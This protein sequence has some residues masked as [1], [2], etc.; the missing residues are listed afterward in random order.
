MK[1]IKKL[2]IS[3]LTICL[4]L[5][6]ITVV[7]AEESSDDKT[8]FFSSTVL[9]SLTGSN[10]FNL[11]IAESQSV[12]SS[13][14]FKDVPIGSVMNDGYKYFTG[15]ENNYSL[16]E[17]HPATYVDSMNNS[18]AYV[19][20]GVIVTS[21]DEAI[22][23]SPSIEK[24]TYIKD[25][26]DNIV[27]EK[28]FALTINANIMGFSTKE[29]IQ[30]GLEKTYLYIY[31]D[32]TQV[33]KIP[34]LELY[35]NVYN[36]GYLGTWDVK[37]TQ[38]DFVKSEVT[39][40]DSTVQKVTG[41]NLN[42]S[43]SFSDADCIDW[44]NT[45]EVTNISG[46][47]P[48]QCTSDVS[49]YTLEVPC[50][51]D[52][53]VEYKAVSDFGREITGSINIT[54]FED[55]VDP[56]NPELT[57]LKPTLKA[58][59]IP[60]SASEAFEISIVSDIEA[61]VNSADGL[62]LMEELK[63]SDTRYIYKFLINNNGT[64]K[65]EGSPINGG[66][67][68]ELS[69]EI[70]CFSNTPSD[71]SDNPSSIED[72]D[73]KPIISIDDAQASS[74][75]KIIAP[76][77]GDTFNML[78]YVLMTLGSL[79]LLI[80]CM[81]KKKRGMA[82]F[83]A[84]LMILS[85][86]PLT[87]VFSPVEIFAQ[88]NT[89]NEG[90][91]G[92]VSNQPNGV[93]AMGV[94]HAAYRV[95]MIDVNTGDF[96]FLKNNKA[97]FLNLSSLDT[98]KKL[99]KA[100]VDSGKL[101][102]YD[103]KNQW[104][105]TF[106]G[107]G[108]LGNATTYRSIRDNNW[109][110]T[111]NT[112]SI[113]TFIGKL[114]TIWGTSETYKTICWFN[115]GFKYNA[116]NI[117]DALDSFLNKKDP[118]KKAKTFNEF[119]YGTFSADSVSGKYLV[120][121]PC[122]EWCINGTTDPQILPYSLAY[123]MKSKNDFSMYS[124]SSF[125]ASNNNYSLF[126]GDAYQTEFID[127][128]VK[129]A[130]A[131]TKK[132]GVLFYFMD[133]PKVT[134]YGK[135]YHYYASDFIGASIPGSTSVN[136]YTRLMRRIDEVTYENGKEVSSK[137]I[138]YEYLNG[139]SWKELKSGSTSIDKIGNLSASTANAYTVATSNTRIQTFKTTAGAHYGTTILSNLSSTKPSAKWTTT[140][141]SGS[142]FNV[143]NK[144]TFAGLT[145]GSS[146]NFDA[147]ANAIAN[148]P[149]L[150]SVRVTQNPSKQSTTASTITNTSWTV[151]G[152]DGN[153]T[154]HDTG[155]SKSDANSNIIDGSTGIS[156]GMIYG[157]KNSS[158]TS[159]VTKV[160]VAFKPTGKNTVTVTSGDKTSNYATNSSGKFNLDY[161]GLQYIV[162]VPNYASKPSDAT[163]KSTLKGAYTE[164]IN[165]T[166]QNLF[167]SKSANGVV[168]KGDSVGVG[169][170]AKDSKCYGY[171]VYALV[172][173]TSAYKEDTFKDSVTLQDYQLN[174][175]TTGI[176]SGNY[177]LKTAKSNVLFSSNTIGSKNSTAN[178][179]DI[180]NTSGKIISRDN[181]L[182]ANKSLPL[183]VPYGYSISR[184][185]LKNGY[186]YNMTSTQYNLSNLY[187]VNVTRGLVE[188]KVISSIYPYTSAAKTQINSNWM[189]ANNF[190]FSNKPASNS[191]ALKIAQRDSNALLSSFSDIFKFK[192]E[193]ASRNNTNGGRYLY[194]NGSFTLIKSAN[195]LLVIN[196]TNNAS[197]N[198]ARTNEI[199]I[200]LTS[201]IKKYNS[202]DIITGMIDDKALGTTS[203]S[204]GSTNGF[205]YAYAKCNSPILKYY[206]EVFMEMTAYNSTGYSSAVKY[207]VPTMGDYIRQTQ[208]G[209]LYFMSIGTSGNGSM[210]GNTTA[211]MTA[212][213]GAIY[214][215]SDITLQTTDGGMALNFYG[216]SLDIINKDVDTSG[217]ASVVGDSSNVYKDW[218][219]SNSTSV[220]Q[221]EFGSWVNSITNNIDVDITMS[222]SNGKKYSNFS[223]SFSGIKSYT[224]SDTFKNAYSITVKHGAIDTSTTGYKNMINQIKSDYGCSSF[225]EAEALFKSS[226]IEEAI[227]AS[228]E[229]DTS[230]L[231][232][233]QAGP[234]GLGNNSHWYDEVVR[235]FV[236]RRYAITG[237]SLGDIVIQ[238]KIDYD[239]NTSQTVGSGIGSTVKG[240][241]VN[242]NWLVSVYLSKDTAGL[243]KGTKLVSD[244]PVSG[245][246]FKV[247]YK[248]TE[249]A[250]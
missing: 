9:N 26:S 236:I 63:E 31:K 60:D 234:S 54:G 245:A 24:V 153:A 80:Y 225:A 16:L 187:S 114:N 202:S 147:M 118:T 172:V 237:L 198:G 129:D 35:K 239:A 55:L 173:D 133:D 86:V 213:D 65:F 149:N 150:A 90:G 3:A 208:S 206:P 170:I 43:S 184:A 212:S 190:S 137:K 75:D 248:T 18:F 203:A 32:A 120:V 232:K 182:I 209:S 5:A 33:A 85:A 126:G 1:F 142:T 15:Y 117:T 64:Y 95:Y 17:Y 123:Y 53:T 74:D 113:D 246:D 94:A 40:K 110:K 109:Y 233:S 169:T 178:L 66:D 145:Y 87:N 197:L 28:D 186:N 247:S 231:N 148:S 49:S 131:R 62:L 108:W 241:N 207:A 226:G 122:T 205:R 217:Y 57:I 143:G 89:G 23:Q 14:T 224:T 146:S 4:L 199:A 11:D 162:V 152:M 79:A 193:Y 240:T 155:K 104:G 210:T 167:T 2:M 7:S 159:S 44:M 82:M 181:T 47:T 130:G 30:A 13:N 73:N 106:W 227:K 214:R 180:S 230:S 88:H 99:E 218:G 20:N 156:V 242:G 115:D 151:N 42:I 211:D 45:F 195:N 70:N 125:L 36:K 29:D 194:R 76:A 105:E 34:L 235:T 96:S 221:S 52:L 185:S 98:V 158:V 68:T 48:L 19:T 83:L 78:F 174:K 12:I 161:T 154:N 228:I 164:T 91:N 58:E 67:T 223:T 175:L 139:S 116:K 177:H 107:S 238:D 216:Y 6:N 220:L 157:Y 61:V 191:E 219:N 200:K 8:Y 135:R 81:I 215:G 37:V 56:Y 168:Q 132:S 179:Y 244:A 124:F 201:Y 163:I 141:V 188:N 111:S 183:I 127:T 171:T 196:D 249:D 160:T 51:S 41:V 69:V 10:I 27:A 77:T 250:D 50:G 112:M 97:A 84:I 72:S 22:A 71:D 25:N 128:K 243:T 92:G 101:V 189:N 140:Y 100:W 103:D 192:S 166:F 46:I 222:L 21:L 38:G 204:S 134:T 138:G 59:G 102:I 136:Q 119:I 165:T 121:E 93:P 39:D 176:Y 144:Y 229:S